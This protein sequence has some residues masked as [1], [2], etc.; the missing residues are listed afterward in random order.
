MKAQTSL[1]SDRMTYPP[2]Q[3]RAVSADRVRPLRRQVLRPGQPD[4]AL[5]YAGD[6]DPETLHAAIVLDTVIVGVA[7][8]M[9]DPH[10]RDPQAGDW[11][12]RG[13]ASAPT[14]RDCGVGSALLRACDVHARERGA[15]RLW[16]NARV[17]A[18]TLYER[19]GL[20][21]EGERFEIATLGTHYLMS[22]PL[23]A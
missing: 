3:P 19:G 8:V 9:R 17:R 2:L 12:I 4:A 22:K 15:T 13:M 21:V 16:C 20:V 10:P 14:L 18:R 6:E 23:R 5:V 1:G 11:R 7:S